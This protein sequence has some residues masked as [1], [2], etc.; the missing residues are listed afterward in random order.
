MKQEHT[1]GRAGGVVA[2]ALLSLCVWMPHRA[3]AQDAVRQDLGGTTWRLVSL[4][5]SGQTVMPD[6]Q[7]K[8]TLSFG[9]K[10]AVAIHADC[11]RGH[12]RYSDPSG[13]MSIDKV[14][15]TRA[16]CAPGSVADQFAR[17]IGFTQSFTVQGGK[18]LLGISST[19]DTI[20][21]EPSPPM[22]S[23]NVGSKR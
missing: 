1:F 6:D 7:Q 10:G 22:R 2:I 9:K 5:M 4:T 20:R 15:L 21:F 19:G 8:Y 11:N 14:T 3:V 18:L 17:A 12:A 13:A 23:T 16:R